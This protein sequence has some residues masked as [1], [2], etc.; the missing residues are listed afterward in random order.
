MLLERAERGAGNGP[1][2]EAAGRRVAELQAQTH[3]PVDMNAACERLGLAAL[4]TP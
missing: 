1:R 4:R 2:A 3:E